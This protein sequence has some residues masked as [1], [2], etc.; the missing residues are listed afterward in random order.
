MSSRRRYC[1]AVTLIVAM[2]G[3]HA[4]GDYIAPYAKS[5]SGLFLGM[6]NLPL[7]SS[8][9]K[10]VIRVDNWFYMDGHLSVDRDFNIWAYDL[11]K[12]QWDVGDGTEVWED[13]FIPRANTNDPE[14]FDADGIC[15]HKYTTPGFYNVSLEVTDTDYDDSD[16]AVGDHTDEDPNVMPYQV[17]AF[18][19]DI[20]VADYVGINDD[21]DDEDGVIDYDDGYDKDGTPGN[22]DDVN[23]DENDLAAVDLS[24]SPSTSLGRVK[25]SIDSSA[26]D[27]VKIWNDPAKGRIIC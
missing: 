13:P 1:I 5:R 7:T 15:R 4:Q 26:W 10:Y 17:I 12:W 3:I 19:L 9:S 2:N 21:D 22:A 25:L 23:L 27:C 14:D 16:G 24:F 6:P 8:R 18:D 11:R 20:A